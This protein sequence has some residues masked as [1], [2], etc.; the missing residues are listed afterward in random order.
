METPAALDA[1][2]ELS[3]S[4][5]WRQRSGAINS[6]ARLKDLRE[7]DERRLEKRVAEILKDGRE[8]FYVKKDAAF[9]TGNRRYYGLIP[10]LVACLDHAHYSV[11]YSAAEALRQLSRDATA[12]SPDVRDLIAEG[13]KTS[14]PDLD[15]LGLVPA[16]YAATDLPADRN[17]DV[18]EAALGL[19]RSGET[20]VAVAIA[21]L[22]KSVK[23]EKDAQQRRLEGLTSRLAQTWEVKAVLA[24]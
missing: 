7:D 4:K 5:D 8:V 23:P 3:Y 6:L 12:G 10:D 9:A 21:K 24:R 14:L 1:L 2:V 18:A 11:R 15:P 20:E 13:L 22:L 19:R 17:M 16:I